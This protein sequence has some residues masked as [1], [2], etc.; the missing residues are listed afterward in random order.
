[1]PWGPNERDRESESMILDELKSHGG[2][3]DSMGDRLWNL[4]E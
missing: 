1:V 4:K 2:T 3:V